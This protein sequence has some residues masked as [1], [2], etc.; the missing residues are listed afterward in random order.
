MECHWCGGVLKGETADEQYQSYRRH[1]AVREDDSKTRLVNHNPSP[2]Q[3]AVAY[4]M[5]QAGKEKQKAR[6]EF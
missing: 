6:D 3:W 1:M 2:A 5:I 4:E